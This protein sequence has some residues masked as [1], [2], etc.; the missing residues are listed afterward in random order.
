MKRF[1]REPLL[2]FLIGGALI[3]AIYGL[4]ADDPMASP[5]RVV[6][7]EQRVDKLVATFQRTWMRPPAAGELDA[8]IQD[9]VDEEILVREGLALGLDRDDPVIR[10]RLRQKMEFLRVDLGEQENATDAELTAYL[11]ANQERFEEPARLSF[12]Q[13]F[14]NPDAGSPAARRRANELLGKLQSGTPDAAGKGDSTLLPETMGSAS[15]RE[16]GTVF[17]ADFAGDVFALTGDDWSGPLASSYGLHLVRVGERVAARKLELEEARREVE[18]D[19][20]TARR[21]EANQRFLRELRERYEVE[22]RMPNVDSAPQL[23]SLGR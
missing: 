1:L 6:V 13:V 22:I 7:D 11:L 4:A 15:E 12:R 18:R 23:S 20:E 14:V 9:F 5:D 8:L 16:I 19:Y 3:Y 10:R 21:A 17:G 2:H